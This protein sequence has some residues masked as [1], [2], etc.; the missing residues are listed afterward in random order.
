MGFE[1]WGLKSGVKEKVIIIL[2]MN[3]NI[4]KFSLK[5]VHQ[6]RGKLCLDENSGYNFKF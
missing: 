5:K 2:Y 1:K 3:S 6:V 4:C